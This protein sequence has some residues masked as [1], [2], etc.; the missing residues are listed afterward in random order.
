MALV[1]AIFEPLQNR[2]FIPLP[3]FCDGDI[4]LQFGTQS[5]HPL[6]TILKDCNRSLS[7]VWNI[8]TSHSSSTDKTTNPFNHME[9]LFSDNSQL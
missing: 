2:G 5:N 8:L 1:D 9:F 6:D 7:A 4:A 3:V